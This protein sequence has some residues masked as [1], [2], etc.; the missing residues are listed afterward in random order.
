MEKKNYF[1]HNYVF[2][3]YNINF[4]KLGNNNNWFRASIIKHKISRLMLM[5]MDM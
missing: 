1:I 5:R 2:N 4:G 3:N